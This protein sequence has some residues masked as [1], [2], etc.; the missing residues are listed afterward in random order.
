MP[1][2]WKLSVTGSQNHGGIFKRLFL[3]DKQSRTQR[4]SG[5]NDGRQIHPENIHIWDVGAADFLLK[6]LLNDESMIKIVPD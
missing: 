3:S 2:L 6:R 4:Y 1:K 5:W